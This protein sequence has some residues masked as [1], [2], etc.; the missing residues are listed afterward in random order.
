MQSLIEL[1]ISEKDGE[2]P[3]GT[4]AE[5]IMFGRPGAPHIFRT[6]FL[7]G[8]PEERH[9]GGGWRRQK[10]TGQRD[11]SWKSHPYPPGLHP[12]KRPGDH[13]WVVLILQ[14][15]IVFVTICL[16]AMLAFV[17]L[18]SGFSLTGNEATALLLF[19][20]IFFISFI[21]QALSMLFVYQRKHFSLALTGA[22]FGIYLVP[23]SIVM[24]AFLIRQRR[25]FQKPYEP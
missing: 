5:D 4:R 9:G 19:L 20:F 12:P 22:L 13:R 21:A 18:Y 7:P 15:V 6:G 14:A 23:I 1:P 16:F 17:A 8:P 25:F 2:T 3:D 11:F 24:I 10:E